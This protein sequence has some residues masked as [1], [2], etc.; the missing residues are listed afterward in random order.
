MQIFNTQLLKS[1]YEKH[2]D[3]QKPLQLW[4]NDVSGKAWK[5][6]ADVKRDF[7]SV[8]IITRTRVV[9]NIRGNKY[10]L[11]ADVNY[12]K[13]FLEILWIGTHAEYD[14]INVATIDRLK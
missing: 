14:K 9:F 5:I 11:V 4:K 12:Q 1:A 2:A 7:N 8:S 13:G 10:R 3:L 6:S